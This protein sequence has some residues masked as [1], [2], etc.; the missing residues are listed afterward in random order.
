MLI[1]LWVIISYIFHLKVFYKIS[2]FQIVNVIFYSLFL[3]SNKM[4]EENQSNYK[5]HL[6]LMICIQHSIQSEKFG[7]FTL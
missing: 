1:L 3:E 5:G 6:F 2:V 4:V 7:L